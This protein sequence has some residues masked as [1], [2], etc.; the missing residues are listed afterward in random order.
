MIGVYGM[1]GLGKTTLVQEVGRKAE[2]D[3]LFNDI[4]FVEVTET[5]DV[6]KVQT[7]IADKLGVEF[8]N[9]SER[10]SKL[11]ERW[12]SG[13]KILLILD[14]IWEDLDLKTIGIP[15]K[16][17]HGGCKLLLT[18][19]NVD[20]LEKMGSTNHFGMGTLNEGESWSLFKKMAGNCY[21][22]F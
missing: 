12:N 6:K 14:N 2:K 22:P 3:N 10:A 20:T 16:M 17:D 21:N 19:R 8:N 18:T 5:L 11:Y 4:V 1:G 15:S 9:E 13:K 7:E